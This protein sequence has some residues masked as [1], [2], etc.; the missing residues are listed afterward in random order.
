MELLRLVRDRG[1]LE[2]RSAAALLGVS[3]ETVRR[4]LR[5][6]ESDGLVRRSYGVAFPVESGA[7]ETALTYRESN[8]AEEKQRIAS[9]AVEHLGEAQTLFLDEGYQTRLVAEA[10]PD[11]R[12]FTVVTSS[13]P[14]A[15]R[16]SHR[17]NVQV[18]ILGGRVRGTTL[19][20]VDHWAADMLASFVIDLAFIGAN[21]VSEEA[22]L[23]TPDPA[24]ALVKSAAVR[25]ARH[26]IF[27]GAHHKF[28]VS[29]F[30][31]F[32]ALADFDTM[33]TGMELS[34]SH[35]SRFVAAG[36]ALIRV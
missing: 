22:G 17:P 8:N 15:T 36:A 29:T 12:P 35:A 20:I 1:R 7:F 26:R 28:G 18:L 19:G 6:L 31:R 32:A 34:S 16:L 23:T 25:A 14:I 33:I 21:G 24:V 4:D 2:V 30:V 10:L 3:H 9:A 27:V 11:D 5:G 13:L